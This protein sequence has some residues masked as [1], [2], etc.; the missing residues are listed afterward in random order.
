MA[1]ADSQPESAAI[2]SAAS[3]APRLTD[4]LVVVLGGRAAEAR[5]RRAGQDGWCR[6]GSTLERVSIHEAGHLVTAAAL[7]RVVS[8]AAIDVSDGGTSIRGL[9]T[10]TRE[11]DGGTSIRG[12]ATFTRERD[13]EPD[14][15]PTMDGFERVMPDY[16]TARNVAKIVVLLGKLD[17]AGWLKLLRAS[18]WR[19][20]ALLD[21]HWLAVKMLA[22]EIHEKRAVGRERTREL[23]ARW[24][25]VRQHSLGAYLEVCQAGRRQEI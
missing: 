23:L 17:P 25:P 18:W 8:G 20:D 14:R 2:P 13:G 24:M 12:L 5:A 9:A 3:V 4:D 21:K 19:A 7:G 11:R 22:L 10:F 15:P 16:E 1:P 6:H